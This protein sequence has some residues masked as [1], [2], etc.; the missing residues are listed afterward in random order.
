MHNLQRMAEKTGTKAIHSANS[1]FWHVL[2]F[3][4][5]GKRIIVKNIKCFYGAAISKAGNP[6]A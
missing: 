2:S 4:Y 3:V 6:F 1:A 5:T